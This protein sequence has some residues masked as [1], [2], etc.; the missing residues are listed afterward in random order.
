MPKK[1]AKDRLF[2]DDDDDDDTDATQAPETAASS[3][4]A[5]A[6]TT[7][8]IR[9]RKILDSYTDDEEETW[10]EAGDPVAVPV[11]EDEDEVQ[12]DDLD[13]TTRLPHVPMKKFARIEEHSPTSASKQ[14]RIPWSLEE[15]ENL[16][17]RICFIFI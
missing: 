2:E 10:S 17:K 4:H 9:K 11:G 6:G 15:E 12:E 3:A 5:A 1:S 14:K 7:V 16:V 8:P 13:S